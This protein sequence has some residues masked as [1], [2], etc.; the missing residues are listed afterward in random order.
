MD[1]PEGEGGKSFY[2]YVFPT[3]GAY[4]NHLEVEFKTVDAKE[5]FQEDLKAQL[6]AQVQ[7]QTAVWEW[8]PP[9]EEASAE[10]NWFRYDDSSQEQLE[11]SLRRDEATCAR[12]CCQKRTAGG[13]GGKGCVRM[14][15]LGDA[16]SPAPRRRFAAS[17][18]ALRCRLGCAGAPAEARRRNR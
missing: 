7:R 4:E 12:R 15:R 16:P 8:E 11:L 17:S 5:N 9:S 1:E 10:G 13:R 2:F 14:A 18:T 6:Q 3:P